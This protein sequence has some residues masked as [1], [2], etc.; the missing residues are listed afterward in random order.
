[1]G[2]ITRTT[3]VR[4]FD[5]RDIRKH[6]GAVVCVVADTPTVPMRLRLIARFLLARLNEC[7]AAGHQACQRLYSHQSAAGALGLGSGS[8]SKHAGLMWL[9]PRPSLAILPAGS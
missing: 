3:T 1:M 7:V 8:A 6:F 2:F 9:S 5:V 4:N